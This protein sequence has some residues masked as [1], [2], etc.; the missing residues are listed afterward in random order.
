MKPHIH[1]H[2][3]CPSFAGCEN[4]LANFFTDDELMHN[5][6]LTF[7]YRYSPEYE[8]GFRSRVKTDKQVYPLNLMDFTESLNRL[9]INWLKK[10]FKFLYFLVIKYVCVLWNTI[11]LFSLFG[12]DKIDI[13]HI[14]NGGYPAAYSCMAA[15]LAA[16]IRGIPHVVYVVNN[17]ATPYKIFTRWF[18]YLP[19]RLVVGG[20]TRFI[21]GSI[22]ASSALQQVLGLK[23]GHVVN[24]HNGIAH[25]HVTETK[26]QLQER[27][28]LH[29]DR[30]YLGIVAILEERKGHRYL[31]E[32]MK[33][34]KGMGLSSKMPML[35]IEGA[36]SLEKQLKELV[37]HNGLIDE[38][39]FIGTEEKVFNLMNAVDVIVLPSV[40]NEDFPN[41]TIEAMSLGKPVIASRLC[42]IP[43]QI[44]HEISGLLVEPRDVNGLANAIITI[45]QDETL[46][47]IISNNAL[48][49]FNTKFSAHVSV[50]R[51][52]QLYDQLLNGRSA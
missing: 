32:A 51:Y 4:M 14:N 38:V 49:R 26:P 33:M 17:I 3:D 12:R 25:R 34:L 45:M 27:L 29:E 47:T 43:E 10:P 41:V 40:S 19:D 6:R 16:R 37:R 21:C 28:G 9:P 36:G 35:L 42:G 1:Y 20:V 23:I 18:D 24:L 13:L 52:N 15:V 30:F 48:E 50:R 11:V 2:S 44:E 7:S 22:T 5:Y 39:M 46:R 8:K 31:L